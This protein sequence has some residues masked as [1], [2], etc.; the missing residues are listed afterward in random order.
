M[1]AATKRRL[2]HACPL[3]CGSMLWPGLPAAG[4][5]LAGPAHPPAPLDLRNAGV[6]LRYEWLPAAARKPRFLAQLH[7]RGSC[8]GEQM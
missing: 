3:T 7:G 8:I 6:I 4:H 1:W 5:R 2:Y